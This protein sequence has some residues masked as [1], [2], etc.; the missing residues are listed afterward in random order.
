MADEGQDVGDIEMDSGNLYREETF[1]DRRMGTVQRLVPV[2]ARGD[3]DE[4]RPVLYIGQTQVLTPVGAL[5][6]SFDLPAASLEEALAQFGPQAQ[7]ALAG[8][9]QRLEEMRREAASSIIVPGGGAP[10]EGGA[11]GG[12]PGGGIKMP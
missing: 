11:P 3:R 1:T 2:T 9:M 8:A 10:G 12:F 5:P 6:L 4:S 7:Q